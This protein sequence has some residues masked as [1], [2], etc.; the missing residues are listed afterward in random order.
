MQILLILFLIILLPAVIFSAYVLTRPKIPKKYPLFQLADNIEDRIVS[1]F[2]QIRQI[3]DDAF[4][5]YS[6]YEEISFNEL[7]RTIRNTITEVN[8]QL[9][10]FDKYYLQFENAKVE[11]RLVDAA[12]AFSIYRK[13]QITSAN[14]II[15]DASLIM[16]L[17]S[18]LHQIQN[19]G[20]NRLLP[21]LNVSN[22]TLNT[23]QILKNIIIQT[24]EVI[25]S[26]QNLEIKHDSCK[27][28]RDHVLKILKKQIDQLN[29]CLNVVIHNPDQFYTAYNNYSDTWQLF[30]LNSVTDVIY[31]EFSYKDNL[32]KQTLDELRRRSEYEA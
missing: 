31:D 13:K 28:F 1:L 6:V 25:N 30:N 16:K 8:Q 12:K 26:F 2:G 27:N 32:Y 22:D 14:M 3:I 9:E 18:K 20:I 5:I 15:N 19:E 10:M 29:D 17:T 11:P 23:E 24:E 4:S 7:V 21:S